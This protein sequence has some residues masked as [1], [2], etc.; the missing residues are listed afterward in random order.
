ML[1]GRSDGD[2]LSQVCAPLVATHFQP[3][4]DDPIGAELIR[5]LLHPGHRQLAGVVHRLRQDIHLL[6]LAPVRLLVADVIDRRAD[7][8]PERIETR[9]PDE[10]EFVD[11][12]VAGEEATRLGLSRALDAF[13]AV[14]R[15]PFEGCRIVRHVTLLWFSRESGHAERRPQWNTRLAHGNDEL[16]VWSRMI[17]G[18]WRDRRAH[19]VEGEDHI[20][21][22]TTARVQ[23]DLTFV[24]FDH[25]ADDSSGSRF[26]CLAAYLPHGARPRLIQPGSE[27]L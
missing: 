3:D 19:D 27:I 9:L 22:T 24:A 11:R 12:E 26:G 20:G 1:D 8:Q 10:Q 18:D 2:E 7:D 6:V 13:A 4:A 14:S 16:G 21:T 5:F 15:D 23:L 25:H 17:A